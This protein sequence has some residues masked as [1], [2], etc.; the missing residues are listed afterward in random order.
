MANCTA[1]ELTSIGYV[2]R[3]EVKHPVSDEWTII[4]G[5]RDVPALHLQV[6]ALELPVSASGYTRSRPGVKTLGTRTYEPDWFIDQ[7]RDLVGWAA[8]GY[9]LDWR[10]VVVNTANGDYYQQFCAWIE[11][12][13]QTGPQT[14]L[15]KSPMTL[16]PT[17]GY[18]DGYL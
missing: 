1:E 6:A 2:C 17:G 7:H 13:E 10:I 12:I 18:Y 14:E 8:Q 9:T 15:M 11:S 16:H 5:L 4:G 3:L